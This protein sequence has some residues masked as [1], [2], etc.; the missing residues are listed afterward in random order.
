[1]AH[2]QYY[3]HL[4]YMETM[5]DRYK[6]TI[7]EMNETYKSLE[8]C[9]QELRLSEAWQGESFQVFLDK[10]AKWKKEYLIT[11]NQVIALYLFTDELISNTY[12]FIS[13]RMRIE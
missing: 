6:E 2:Y 9:V 7:D 4:E 8:S 1:M 11:M 10:Y 5:R 12:D 3:V 13:K